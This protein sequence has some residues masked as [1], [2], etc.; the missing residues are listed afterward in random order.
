MAF[1]PKKLPTHL[2]IIMDGNGRWAKRR[3]LPRNQ[4]HKAGMAAVERVINYC[5]KYKIKYLTLFAFSTENWKRDKEEIDGIFDLVRN[6]IKD[7][8]DSFVENNIKVDYIGNLKPF[9]EDLV[10]VLENIKKKT[11]KFDELTVVLA[12]NYGGRDDIVRAVNSIINEGCKNI[13]N[14]T[15][16]NHLDTK[17]IPE[18]DIVVR[19]SGEQR[20]SNFMLYQMAYS[21]FYFPKI[22]WP[23]FNE[24]A[25]LK[26]LK[27]YQKRDRR[28]GGI[29]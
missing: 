10:S 27:T 29:K 15:I 24:K 3:G 12:L 4:G 19:T 9:P 14:E 18:P 22:F 6:Y 2:A 1:K 13:T 11:E 25:F 5:L 23:D 16:I 8:R 20:V 7:Y 17:N 26:I 21:E 28:Y